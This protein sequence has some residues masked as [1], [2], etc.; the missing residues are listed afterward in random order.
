MKPLISAHPLSRD[1]SDLPAKPARP[2]RSLA[3]TL[4]EVMVALALLGI[5]MVAIYSSW[6]AIIKG[7]KVAL[8]A[9]AAAQR[10]RISMH[11]LQD[12]L[13]SACMFASNPKYYAF[14]ADSEGDMATLSFAARL[15]KSFPRS[16]KFGDL[17]LRRVNFAVEPGPDSSKQLVLRQ[18]PIFMDPDKDEMQ[19]PLVLAKDVTNFG[20]E[21]LDPRT[22]DWI[23][24]WVSTNQLPKMMRITLG[25]GRLDKF[26]SH[27]QEVRVTTVALP[28]SI[29][30]AQYQFGAGGPGG[31]GGG[32]GPGGAGGAGGAGGTGGGVGGT[33]N[34][35]PP[36][37]GR[38]GKGGGPLQ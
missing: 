34:P 1:D 37:G 20:L 6:Y 24:E 17:E 26:S 29:V 4:L 27:P 21:F 3:F 2:R 18:S 35:Q 22:G 23:S 9:A 31:A 25:L 30:L 33:G 14:L 13:L 7:S 5:I 12:S 8:D 15:P 38:F 19:H 36:V 11:A 10:T 16:G 28:S 32:P